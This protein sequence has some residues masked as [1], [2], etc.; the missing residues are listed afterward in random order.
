MPD[1]AAML[2]RRSISSVAGPDEACSGC[3]RTPLPGERLHELDSGR[4]LCDLCFAEL[5]EES[6]AG[7][8]SERVRG[9][10]RRLNVVP[11]AA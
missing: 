4:R 6:R 1:M 8:S 10:E 5:P 9:G 3:A 2:L 11:K 7:A